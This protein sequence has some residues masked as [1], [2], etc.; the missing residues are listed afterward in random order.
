MS[1]VHIVIARLLI[2]VFTRRIRDNEYEFPADRRIGSAVKTL[3]Q[4]ILTPDPSQ[5]PTLFEILD[6]LFFTQGPVPSYI[7][8]SAHDGP[9]DFSNITPTISDCNFRR[10]RRFALLD[11]G[12]GI[13][14]SSSGSLPQNSSGKTMTST[15]QQQ[16]KEFQKAIQPGSP[17]SA[18]LNSARQPL[19]MG[20][21]QNA[22]DGVASIPNPKESALLRK[23]Q[24]AKESPL[25][26]T[27]VNAD[28]EPNA[29]EDKRARKE[30]EAQKARI[31]AQMAPVREEPEEDEAEIGEDE[32][33]PLAPKEKYAH[34][35][36]KLAT[37]TVAPVSVPASAP[38]PRPLPQIPV[39]RE[40]PALVPSR[41]TR[42]NLPPSSV[43]AASTATL[44]RT[45]SVTASLKGKGKERVVN[46]RG[47]KENVPTA[48]GT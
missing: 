17:I 10:L 34:L 5:R 15:I 16:E 4:Q 19:V 42:E 44:P 25:R 7:P 12:A 47:E 33:N 20:V 32:P 9:P 22:S 43:F 3:I 23:L 35:T 2:L 38:A 1:R 11:Q 37:T 39:Q 6:H 27:Y 13:M 18:L 45:E 21:A 48:S 8:S 30:L 40:R 41:S 36:E 28:E 24:A 26:R 46:V 14:P 31:V 29:E